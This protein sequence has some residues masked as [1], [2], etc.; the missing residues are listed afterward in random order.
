MQA[1]LLLIA[2]QQPTLPVTI[3]Q[4]FNCDSLNRPTTSGGSYNYDAAGNLLGIIRPPPR[5]TTIPN[6]TSGTT[7]TGRLLT[8]GWTAAQNASGLAL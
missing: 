8:L 7:G 4:I 2:L 3:V 5:K 6:P 1:L